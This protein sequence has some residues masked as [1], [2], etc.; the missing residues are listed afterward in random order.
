MDEKTPADEQV[1]A[2][3]KQSHERLG[4][5]E[6]EMARLAHNLSALNVRVQ[7][8]SRLYD[9]FVEKIV[10]Y[11]ALGVVMLLMYGLYHLGEVLVADMISRG[12]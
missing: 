2:F 4:L 6:E 3:F 10:E 12:P 5:S 9:K 1:E 7:R 8:T 11:I